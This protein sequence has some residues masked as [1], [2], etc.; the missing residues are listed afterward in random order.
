MKVAL[1]GDSLQPHL[2]GI[3]RYT[4]EL[5]RGLPDDPRIE[6][7]AL[8]AREQLVAE[9]ER[10]LSQ[11]GLP[12]PPKYL[13]RW[14]R[15]R[16]WRDWR[17]LEGRLFHGPNYFLPRRVERGVVT[18]H[19][20]S[21]IRF[22]ETHSAERLRHFARDLLPSLERAVHVITDTETVRQEVIAEFGLA[23]DK[24]SAVHLGVGRNFR[25]RAADDLAA[26]LAPFG[27]TPGAY[28]LSVSTLEP[29]KRIAELIA[30]WRLLPAAT[31]ART[32]LVLVGAKGWQDES[33]LAS[34]ERGA[35]EGW[36]RPLGYVPEAA[37]PELYAGARLFIYP[38]I[39]EGFGLPPL[40]AMASA[41]PVVVAGRSCLP[42]VCG[43]AAFYVD[44]DDLDGFAVTLGQALEDES[45]R[46]RN[47]TR[48]LARAAAFRWERCISKTVDVYEQAAR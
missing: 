3:G 35:A 26:V 22:P 7:V 44:P 28:G 21:V 39:Y 48:G 19:D 32:P 42:E 40:E 43:D 38:S 13:R 37:L 31:R 41:V 6:S 11:K 16:D 27:L 20:L 29:R 33:L 30:A 47:V 10:L 1:W 15:W 34:I 36:L 2:T 8:W 18:V 12:R 17:A 45:Q 5:L 25:P 46:C 9:P 24:V 23:A 4:L 14:R